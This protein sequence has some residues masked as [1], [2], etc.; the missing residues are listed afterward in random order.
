[1][2]PAEPAERA[3]LLRHEQGHFDITNAMAKNAREDV[4]AR[5]ATLT[6]TKTACGND[7]AH[8]AARDEYDAQ[9]RPVLVQLLNAWKS[10]M[11][12]AQHD[13]DDQTHHGENAGKQSDWE[14]KNLWRI[15]GLGPQ[16]AAAPASPAAPTAPVT[17][18]ATPPPATPANPPARPASPPGP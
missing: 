11:A 8:Q 2:W 10:S 16:S 4:K 17:T 5:S 1:V 6:V 18:P 14:T 9:V 13:Y 3:R 12:Q 15:A 7:A